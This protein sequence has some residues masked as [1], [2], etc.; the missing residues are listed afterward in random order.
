MEESDLERLKTVVHTLKGAGGSAG[1][2]I[3]TDKA[4]AIENVIANDDIEALTEKVA[5]LAKL[6]Q[7]VTV[8]R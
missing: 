7:R 1:F 8:N 2:P 3:L 5:E 4:I 6:C